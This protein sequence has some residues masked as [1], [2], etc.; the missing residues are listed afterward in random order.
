MWHLYYFEN[1]R[2]LFI[3]TF[4]F[5]GKCTQSLH[6]RKPQTFQIGSNPLVLCYVFYQL[7]SAAIDNTHLY[8]IWMPIVL[9][10]HAHNESLI[11]LF[12]IKDYGYEFNVWRTNGN[13]T[14]TYVCNLLKIQRWRFITFANIKKYFSLDKPQFRRSY[15]VLTDVSTSIYVGERK[16]Q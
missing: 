2:T 8:I 7:Y 6:V 5:A 16:K 10:S 9:K 14:L 15:R 12:W 3:L 11:V 1:L 4:T 13:E